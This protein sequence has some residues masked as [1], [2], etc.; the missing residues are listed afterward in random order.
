VEEPTVVVGVVT[1]AHGI[2]GEVSVQN[3]SD[4]PERWRP[5]GRVR[6]EDGRELTIRQSRPHGKRMLVRFEEVADRSDADALRGEV[7]VVPESWLPRLERGEWWAHQLEG[8]LVTTVAGRSLGLL[9]G[10]IANPA[11]DLWVAVDAD[12]VETL[13]P[14]LEDVLVEVD[15]AAR[16]VVVRDVPGLTAPEDDGSGL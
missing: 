13:I 2:R 1:A 8:C 6:L 5:G 15:V 11:N 4:N 16:R 10:V 9:T 7:L 14:A 12:G 3:R